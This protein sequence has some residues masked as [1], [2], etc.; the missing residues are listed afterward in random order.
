MNE[1]AFGFLITFL[2][3]GIFSLVG[4]LVVFYSHYIVVRDERK[5][6]QKVE[7]KVLKIVEI[8]LAIL[9]VVCIIG[10]IIS[11]SNYTPMNTSSGSD[12]CSVCGKRTANSRTN[13][14]GQC[15]KN[16][17]YASEAKDY[18]KYYY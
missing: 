5:A 11:N 3:V 1:V 12:M 2:M 18:A 15:Y 9:V 16:Y 10:F 4:L 8:V 17:K 7:H 6:G 13:M 14:C